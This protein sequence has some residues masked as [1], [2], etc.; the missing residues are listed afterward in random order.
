MMVSVMNSIDF[1]SMGINPS[2]NA[3]LHSS[4]N[5]RVVVVALFILFAPNVWDKPLGGELASLPSRS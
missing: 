4:K 3:L 2:A 5:S 1:S